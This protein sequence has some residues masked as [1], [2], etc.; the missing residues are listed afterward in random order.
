MI[1]SSFFFFFFYLRRSY[2]F[3]FT[4]ETQAKRKLM[5]FKLRFLI[6]NFF[7]PFCFPSFFFL[8]R[9]FPTISFPTLLKIRLIYFPTHEDIYHYHHYIYTT[10]DTLAYTQSHNWTKLFLEENKNNLTLFL[11]AQN[12]FMNSLAVLFALYIHKTTVC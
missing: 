1:D 2:T 8:Q 6:F 5:C 10:S 7:V 4:C 12:L 11:Y 9:T 3:L